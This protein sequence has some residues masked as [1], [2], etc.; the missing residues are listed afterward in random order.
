[1]IKNINLNILKTK[2]FCH[3]TCLKTYLLKVSYDLKMFLRLFVRQMFL[4]SSFL[5]LLWG[6]NRRSSSHQQ[7]ELFPSRYTGSAQSF[8]AF[9]GEVV[10]LNRTFCRNRVS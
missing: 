10:T 1:M 7:R 3:K 8:P 2:E 6:A 5:I 4:V 9:S